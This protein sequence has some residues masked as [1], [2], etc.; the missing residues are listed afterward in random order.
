[1]QQ[2]HLVCY[3]DHKYMEVSKTLM[4]LLRA[5]KYWNKSNKLYAHQ[6][7]DSL[8]IQSNNVRV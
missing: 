6:E 1:M 8:E 4:L 7:K 2:L 5:I 3:I